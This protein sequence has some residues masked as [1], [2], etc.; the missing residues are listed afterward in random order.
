MRP[1]FLI[2]LG[3]CFLAL[4]GVHVKARESKQTDVVLGPF[5][6][7]GE[8]DDRAER[9]YTAIHS[10][11]VFISSFRCRVDELYK[12]TFI[13]EDG[14]EVDIDNVSY[15]GE[16]RFHFL[17]LTTREGG[18]TAELPVGE[19]LRSVRAIELWDHSFNAERH[20]E[21]RLDISNQ[22]RAQLQSLPCPYDMICY[23]NGDPGCELAVLNATY[24]IGANTRGYGHFAESEQYGVAACQAACTARGDCVMFTY[25]DSWK[26]CWLHAKSGSYF[27]TGHAG[28]TVGWKNVLT[29][30][31]LPCHQKA[32]NS[33]LSL[34]KSPLVF[35]GT[36]P[37]SATSV[38]VP[39]K[40][41]AASDSFLVVGG[42]ISKLKLT[43]AGNNE[44]SWTK[45]LDT[46]STWQKW[47]NTS[48]NVHC[49]FKCSKEDYKNEAY[50][51]RRHTY[52]SG[53]QKVN[54]NPSNGPGEY[55]VQW[56]PEYS[57]AQMYQ[58]VGD[59]QATYVKLS[60]TS[61]REFEWKLFVPN[62]GWKPFNR[63]SDNTRIYCRYVDHPI[64]QKENVEQPTQTIPK[65]NVTVHKPKETV[66]QAIPPM[67]T[68]NVAV[69]KPRVKVQQ[70]TQPMLKKNVA[71]RKPKVKVQ[72]PTQ[73]MPK[74]K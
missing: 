44:F 70:P 43:C 8:I 46:G 4:C 28:Y 1:A 15:G 7:R 9:V 52:Y 26:W 31:N 42:A 59:Q 2:L 10:R 35:A 39:G 20:R 3:C 25:K 45:S 13:M 54:L 55:S 47:A 16:C 6:D 74:K 50:R 17:P 19:S 23:A 66:E 51:L 61:E 56:C 33:A 14:R 24:T 32:W 34:V 21:F 37:N 12:F 40:F 71:V 62:V 72:Q 65:K 38:I 58:M 41:C 69:Q 68:K 36:T 60:C 11:A 48:E 67:S 27:K 30:A 73:T 53:L 49:K 57:N 22:Q 5:D 29:P 64:P 63:T 18:F